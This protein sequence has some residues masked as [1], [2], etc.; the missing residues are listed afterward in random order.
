MSGQRTWDASEASEA[1]L[2]LPHKRGGGGYLFREFD[3]G[4]SRLGIGVFPPPPV[5]FGTFRHSV[6]R[7]VCESLDENFSSV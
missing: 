1:F 7:S 5:F 6:L 3:K 4:W 2:L